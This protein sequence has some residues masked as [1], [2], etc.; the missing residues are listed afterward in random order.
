VNCSSSIRALTVSVL[1]TELDESSS[2]K[3]MIPAPV[4]PVISAAT[5]HS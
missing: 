5:S 1:Q 3:I 4:V 2:A